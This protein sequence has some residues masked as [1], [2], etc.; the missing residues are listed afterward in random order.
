MRKRGSGFQS[1]YAEKF[2]W[3]RS[4]HKVFIDDSQ[5][6]GAMRYESHFDKKLLPIF[7]EMKRDGLYAK[8]TKPESV[9]PSLLVFIQ[10]VAAD[11]NHMRVNANQQTG[12][13]TKTR[14]LMG[15]VNVLLKAAT[16]NAP[17]NTDLTECLFKIQE[18]AVALE[19]MMS[20]YLEGK[21]LEIK[22]K[23]LI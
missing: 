15:Q 22:E 3:L 11:L 9:L 23:H 7:E 14:T 12:I 1:T 13:L 16:Y 2:A 10:K 21:P 20:S 18:Y 6:L 19:D 17:Q 8:V 5:L 4:H